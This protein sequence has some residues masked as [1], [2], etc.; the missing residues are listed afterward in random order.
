MPTNPLPFFELFKHFAPASITVPKTPIEDVV[1]ILSETILRFE[2]SPELDEAL[3]AVLRSIAAGEPLTRGAAASITPTLGDIILREV[4]SI[5][6]AERKLTRETAVEFEFDHPRSHGCVVSVARGAEPDRLKVTI[7]WRD[8]LLN[9]SSF[10]VDERWR[11]IEDMMPSLS[12]IYPEAATASP[13]GA[14]P[15]RYTLAD[16]LTIDVVP[17]SE[18]FADP[19][20]DPHLSLR[21]GL[22][23][24]CALRSRFE[25]D[26]ERLELEERVGLI[27]RRLADSCPGI[28][29]VRNFDPGLHTRETLTRCGV[30]PFLATSDAELKGFVVDNIIL[31][32]TRASTGESLLHDLAHL[33]R[34]SAAVATPS[35]PP[36]LDRITAIEAGGQS[37]EMA[38]RLFATLGLPDKEYFISAL[39][40]F[41]AH[42]DIEYEGDLIDG[43][44]SALSAGT[45]VSVSLGREFLVEGTGLSGDESD[46]STEPWASEPWK[47]SE[48]PENVA[49]TR[50]AHVI[51]TVPEEWSITPLVGFNG[52]TGGSAAEA[53]ESP[54]VGDEP[55]L[56]V[57]VRRNRRGDLHVPEDLTRKLL[58]TLGHTPDKLPVIAVEDDPIGGYRTSYLS[59]SV[60]VRFWM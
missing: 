38:S 31:I 53:L 22:A 52:P 23:H 54:F 10:T 16:G 59:D 50:F 6:A 55:T 48:E 47:S 20:A 19:L 57:S 8:R 41:V 58:A 40:D 2:D 9:Q 44:L 51:P 49:L 18:R 14:A 7:E 39:S 21:P 60:R 15:Y 1:A 34:L 45:P 24:L 3:E 12:A 56:T 35:L 37:P 17:R 46:E 26:E 42:E 36:T 29:I 33:E 28:S 43:L 32:A 11:L 4:T 27:Y 25:E 13:S 30:V 5:T